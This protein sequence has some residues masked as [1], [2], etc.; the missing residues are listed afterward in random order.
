M[1]RLLFICS[2]NQLR[3]PTAEQ[4]FAQR[5]GIEAASAG[6]NHDSA[7]TVTPA[8]VEWADMI[9]VM[10]KAHLKKLRSRFGHYLKDQKVVCLDIPDKYE[11]MEPALVALLEGR[12]TP[13]LIAPHS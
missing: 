12:V 5:E 3:S 4:V 6:L 7:E 11:F 2:R 1:L 8:L 10:E 13:F 9:F